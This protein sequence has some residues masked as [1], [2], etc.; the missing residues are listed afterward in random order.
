MGLLGLSTRLAQAVC[1]GLLTVFH[2]AVA[3]PS[4]LSSRGGSTVSV[5]SMS[6][7]VL[8]GLAGQGPKTRYYDFVVTETPGSPDGFNRPMLVVNGAFRVYIVTYSSHCPGMYPGPTIEVNQH[9]TLVVK[10]TNHMPNRT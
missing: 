9:D 10:V 6:N 1:L 8:N 7:F 4:A 2:G 5:P 3:A